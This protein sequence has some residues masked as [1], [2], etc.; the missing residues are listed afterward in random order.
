MDL[1][2]SHQEECGENSSGAVLNAELM[3]QLIASAI[4]AEHRQRRKRHA[5]VL[6]RCGSFPGGLAR[7]LRSFQS[8]SP[9]KWI[10]TRLADQTS[11]KSKSKRSGSYGHFVESPEARVTDVQLFITREFSEA[12]MLLPSQDSCIVIFNGLF[13]EGSNGLSQAVFESVQ[14]SL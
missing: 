11:L 6:A 10:E 12:F 8:S 2:K 1:S 7:I 4:G 13:W 14:C 3:M 5:P 9:M